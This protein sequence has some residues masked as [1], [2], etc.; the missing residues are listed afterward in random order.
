MRWFQ[1]LL[2]RFRSL[3][4]REPSNAALSEE[5]QFHLERQIEENIT[6]GMSPDRARAAARESF[7]DVTVAAE[8][9]Y[10][11]R[12]VAWLDDLTQDLRY[13]LRTLVKHRSFTLVTVLTLALGI[14][15][16]TAIFSL[17]NA[18]LIRSLPYGE[19]DR[20]VYLFTPNPRWK[21]PAE[22]FGPSNADYFDLKKQSKSF[23]AA[24]LFTQTTYNLAGND[25]AERVS[26]A[27][28]DADF[29]GTLEVTPE[30]GRGFDTTDEQPGNEHVA[31]I[32]HALW[33]TMLGG[34]ADVLGATLR[35]DGVSYQVVGV[36]P[37]EFGYP[38]KSDLA[39]G[40]GHVET[41]DL[42]VPWALIPQQ[43]MERRP[44]TVMLSRA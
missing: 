38:H 7:G 22:I 11:T 39:Y 20:L 12:G 42:W 8:K 4:E 10:E 41:T 27:K 25:R 29:F 13:A 43:R 34:K 36:M 16:C 32:S 18:V 1:S 2:R 33:Q 40:N 23:S 21:L 14:G 31:V 37:A 15:A 5:L 35:L 3:V 17:V 24:T 28:V 6:Q 30:V 26:A 44:R 19:P 9:C